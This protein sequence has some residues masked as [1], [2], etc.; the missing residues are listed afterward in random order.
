M[1]ASCST[2]PT[3]LARNVRFHRWPTN[4]GWLRDSGCIFV[5]AHRTTTH[6][7]T[8]TLGSPSGTSVLEP[9]LAINFRFNA[10]AKYSNYRHDE[11]IGALMANVAQTRGNP[12]ATPHYPRSPR[13]RFHR[14]QRRRHPPNHRRM[15]AQQSPA[16]QSRHEAQRLRKNLRR[17]PRRPAHHLA[18]QRHPR[19]RHPRPRRRPD[20]LRSSRHTSSP[21]SNPIAKT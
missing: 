1:P 4:R 20:P 12:P 5:T 14:R 3:P 10:W 2:E 9:A 8:A 16:T 6:V 11:K 15:P 13:R 19:R 21:W 17:L 18:R 7:G